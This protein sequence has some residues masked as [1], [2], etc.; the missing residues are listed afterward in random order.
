MTYSL[1]NTGATVNPQGATAPNPTLPKNQ[2]VSD[3]VIN[4]P[5]AEQNAAMLGT[6]FLCKG[7]DGGQSLFV[8]DAERSIPGS[9]RILRRL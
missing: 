4:S 7:P 5:M 2:Q 6:P 1:A 3:N 9:L 8:Y